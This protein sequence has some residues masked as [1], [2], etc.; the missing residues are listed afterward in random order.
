MGVSIL[1]NVPFLGLYLGGAI[2]SSA[3]SIFW[4][5]FMRR[6]GRPKPSHGASGVHSLSPSLL[7]SVRV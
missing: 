7:F 2:A 6:D 5:Q 4:N 3:I 1:G